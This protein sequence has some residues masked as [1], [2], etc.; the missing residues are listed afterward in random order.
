V[1]EGSSYIVGRGAFLKV[2]IGE[3]SFGGRWQVLWRAC[4]GASRILGGFAWICVKSGKVKQDRC[5]PERAWKVSG[6][7]VCKSLKNG[8]GR[9][10]SMARGAEIFGFA[11]CASYRGFGGL[12]SINAFLLGVRAV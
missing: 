8:S 12:I 1:A 4:V 10:H 3:K 9:R 11:Q 7:F 5:M 6:N 2:T